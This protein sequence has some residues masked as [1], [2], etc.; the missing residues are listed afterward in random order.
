LN[1]WVINIRI[2][3]LEFFVKQICCADRAET[4][5]LGQFDF[6]KII[7]HKQPFGLR[8]EEVG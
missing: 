8:Q 3:T 5:P 1:T 7:L 4:A 2:K 6:F